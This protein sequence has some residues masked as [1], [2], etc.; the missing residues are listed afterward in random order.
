MLICSVEGCSRPV[1]G[2]GFCAPHYQRNKRGYDMS[3]PVR[4]MPRGRVCSFPGCDRKHRRNG[5]CDSH[6]AQSKRQ[7]ELSALRPVARSWQDYVD[8]FWSQVEKT[9]ECWTWTGYTNEAGYGRLGRFGEIGLILSNRLAWWIQTGQ[10]P[11]DDKMV[12]HSCDNPPCVRP[13]H[14]WLGDAN[15]NIQDMV[16]K[17]RSCKGEKHFKAKLTDNDVIDIRSLRSFGASI[18]D[19]AEAYLV[20]G[21]TIDAVVRRYTWIHIP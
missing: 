19:L 9:D 2:K 4:S 20:A 5:Y 3:K 18:S 12:C 16:E 10:E 7:G 1:G 14:L 11:P 17:G 21:R 15:A 13:D 8:R 6:D